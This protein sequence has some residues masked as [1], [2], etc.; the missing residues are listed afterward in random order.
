MSWYKIN[1]ISEGDNR[2]IGILLCV[3][4]DRT[5]VEYALAGMDTGFFVSKYKLERSKKHKVPSFIKE[6]VRY[7]GS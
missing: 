2:P 1:I 7:A 3:K 4:R 6:Q 5:L